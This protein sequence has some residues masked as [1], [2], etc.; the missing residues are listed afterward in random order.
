LE[1]IETESQVCNL[2]FS[3]I[4]NQFVSTH[5]YSDNLILVWDYERLDVISIFK[6]HRDRVIYMSTSPDGKKIVTGAGDETVRFWNVFDYNSI[7][8]NS[9][10]LKTEKFIIR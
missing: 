8:R 3:K 9:P 7:E 4:S 10:K 2:A 5:G 6:G 1:N